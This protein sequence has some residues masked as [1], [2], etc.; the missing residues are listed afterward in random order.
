M[1]RNNKSLSNSKLDITPYGKYRDTETASH[2]SQARNDISEPAPRSSTF[3]PR[4][5]TRFAINCGVSHAGGIWNLIVTYNA[6]FNP[7]TV[8]IM[9]IIHRLNYIPR[10]QFFT[11]RHRHS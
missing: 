7:I 2:L 8:A 5:E 3:T 1:T 9:L 6:T 10:L 4:L 11:T